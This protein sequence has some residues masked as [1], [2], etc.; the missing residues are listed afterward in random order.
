[1]RILS[2]LTYS[3]PSIVYGGAE[4]QM[5]SLHKALISRGV[6][7]Q[8]LANISKVRALYQKFEDVPVWGASFPWL[9]RSLL[10]PWNLKFWVDLH[11]MLRLVKTKIGPVD[12]IQLT[13]F[14]EP[15]VYAYW[16]SK[17]LHIP[18]IG[19]IA[20]S[21]TYGDFQY[22]AK[23]WLTKRLLPCLVADCSAAVTLDDETRREALQSGFPQE[24]IAIIPNSVVIERLPS[25]EEIESIPN[26]GV[27]LY[28]GRISPQKRL[29][30]LVKA[31][32]ICKSSSMRATRRMFPQLSLVGGGET[33]SLKKLAR[34]C[35][36][37]DDICFYGLQPKP[38]RFF[39]NA[40][41]LVNPSESEGFPNAVLEACAFGVP[42]ILSDIPVHRNIAAHVGMEDFVFPVGD[43]KTL[44]EKLLAFLNL[45]KKQMLSK[46]ILCTEYAEEY[47]CHLRDNAYLALY[48]KVLSRNKTCYAVG[49][50]TI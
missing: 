14:R 2:I 45:T 22:L 7:V 27:I 3:P 17:H 21:G 23:N 11:R 31:Y 36:V 10:H 42:V 43:E 30:S 12:L 6:D 25:H 16:L 1:M 29:E 4:R 41:C 18:W 38:E 44:A 47:S 33:N 15:A 26:A 9:T 28:L 46:R 19:R 32:A 40:L 48:E 13:P 34:Q 5:H 20:C 49:E 8:V 35:G 39:P 37:Q 50:K 24:K